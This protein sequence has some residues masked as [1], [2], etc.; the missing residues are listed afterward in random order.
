MYRI[1]CFTDNATV[2]RTV[3]QRLTDQPCNIQFLP[4]S[5][6]TDELRHAVR[7]FAPDMILFEL[8]PTMDNLSLFFFLRADQAT[9][10]IPVIMLTS[11]AQ[12]DQYAEV[13]GA[14]AHIARTLLP[15][16]LLPTISHHLLPLKS[17]VA[18]A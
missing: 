12:S 16:Q 4:A 13:L 18:A 3:Q 14:N 15:E 8:S 1:V 17:A 9:R 5:R 10:H 2:A 6:L 11:G 7:R